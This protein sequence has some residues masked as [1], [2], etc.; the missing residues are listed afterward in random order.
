MAKAVGTTIQSLILRVFIELNLAHWKPRPNSGEEEAGRDVPLPK[1]LLTVSSPSH[2]FSL[3]NIS[4]LRRL[5]I[6]VSICSCF[7]TVTVDVEPAAN[8]SL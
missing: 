1:K 3:L 7:P 5:D 2:F 8:P 6:W 4:V